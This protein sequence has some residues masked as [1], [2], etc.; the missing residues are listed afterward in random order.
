MGREGID[1]RSPQIRASPDTDLHRW[2]E[3]NLCH[4]CP[5]QAV[6]VPS[7]VKQRKGS[8][9]EQHP[10]RPKAVTEYTE[11]S[12][13]AWNPG[14]LCLLCAAKRLLCVLW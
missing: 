8:T 10:E 11:N 4:L 12:G 6:S 14:V 5:P 7:V 9:T 2:V 1:H 13:C 3:I